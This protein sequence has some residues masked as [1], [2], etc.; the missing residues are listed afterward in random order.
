MV[1]TGAA[2]RNFMMWFRDSEEQDVM[3]T[4]GL[5]GALDTDPAK[6][7]LG[8]YLDD[9]T[10]SKMDWYI[11]S[12]TTYGAPQI[13][14]DGSRLYHVTTTLK[15]NMT[16]EE[17]QKAPKYVTGGSGNKLVKNRG[18]MITYVLLFSPSEGSLANVKVDDENKMVNSKEFKLGQSDSYQVASAYTRMQPL[19][20][21][22]ITYDVITSP[23]AIEDLKLDT[24]PTAQAV[25]GW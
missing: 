19:E 21:I 16:P 17:A 23:E 11:S 20:S 24:T 22:T 7:C 6:P 3:E 25:A 1:Q 15:N 5:T 13:Q 9:I 10:W 14:E 18:E 12:N 8:V 4:V 2:N